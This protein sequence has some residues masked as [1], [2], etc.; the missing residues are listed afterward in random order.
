MSRQ[1]DESLVQKIK[2]KQYTEIKRGV[3]VIV[4]PIPDDDRKGDMDP[5]LLKSS[6]KWLS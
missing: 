3:K 1:Y 6:K 5:R 4:K 2:E